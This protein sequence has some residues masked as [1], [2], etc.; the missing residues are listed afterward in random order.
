MASPETGVPCT[1]ESIHHG[2]HRKVKTMSTTDI[3]KEQRHK[4]IILALRAHL[5]KVNR[6]ISST[7][8]KVIL[9]EGRATETS[10]WTDGQ[11]VWLSQGRIQEDLTNTTLSNTVMR[12]RGRNYHEVSHILFTPRVDSDIHKWLSNT[13][14]GN[15]AILPVDERYRAFLWKAWNVLEDQ[16][17]ETLFT[18]L[19]GPSRPYFRAAILDAVVKNTR[20]GA[21]ESMHGLLHGR[22]YISAQ[23]RLKAYELFAKVHGRDLADRV[24]KCINNYLLVTYPTNQLLAQGC[25]KEMATI[26]AELSGDPST[27]DIAPN[28]SSQA[29]KM[30]SGQQSKKQ[31]DKAHEALGDPQDWDDD[32]DET[33]DDEETESQGSGDAE[34]DEEDGETEEAEGEAG[35]GDGEQTDDGEDGEESGGSE[36]GS[37]DDDDFDGDGEYTDDDGDV[38]DGTPSPGIGNSTTPNTTWSAPKDDFIDAVDEELNDVLQD[39][40][41]VREVADIVR[42]IREMS[43]SEVKMIDHPP[44]P[45]STITPPPQA[46]IA[47]RRLAD[48]LIRLRAEMDE[49]HLRRQTAGML[50]MRRVANRLPWETDIFRQ[51]EPGEYDD[52]KAE[53][54]ILVDLSGSMGTVMSQLSISLWVLCR[55]LESID[56]R[57]TVLGYSSATYTMYQPTERAAG[58]QINVFGAGGSTIPDAALST[59]HAIF[60]GSRHV[61]KAMI[62]LTDGGWGGKRDV[63]EALMASIRQMDVATCLVE[64]RS[65]AHS[66]NMHGHEFGIT[67]ADLNDLPK[68]ATKMVDG[69]LRIP[70]G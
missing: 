62:S 18:T 28:N 37:G 65:G 35:D 42:A 15:V 68:L 41:F 53:F 60:E 10:A 54:V 16:R 51:Y 46:I 22:K 52:A 40:D 57:V 13:A 24:S 6:I 39:K 64:L 11:D 33:E 27:D 29:S 67:M 66:G 25:L 12:V 45:S 63:Q 5:Q 23:T 58:H 34:S 9:S 36:S 26:L 32:P 14:V 31:Q 19:Y 1:V 7:G 2:T 43:E 49:E 20:P 69:L 8:V 21:A 59:A 17:I 50:D 44:P 70:M 38:S 56:S 48:Q 47:S 4:R 3:M 61:R 55:A 30:R